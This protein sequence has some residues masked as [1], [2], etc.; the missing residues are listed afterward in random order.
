MRD[1]I[2]RSY[3]T[4][5][6]FEPMEHK[7]PLQVLVS[8]AGCLMPYHWWLSAGTLL[9]FERENWF[10]EGDTDIDVG[11]LGNI[12]RRVFNDKFDI[13][14]TVDDGARQMQT[15]FLDV[16]QKILF[17]ILHYW[18][19]EEYYYVLGQDGRIKRERYLIDTIKYKNYLNVLWPV[20]GD[21]DAYLTAWYGD[22]RVPVTGGKTQWEYYEVISESGL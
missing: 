17:D 1:L 10:I 11:V 18:P 21:I 6:V 14:R 12:D 13:V 9:G 3:D 8:G 15:V 5:L 7:R 4:P 2:V 19:D 22:W 20:P 16:E